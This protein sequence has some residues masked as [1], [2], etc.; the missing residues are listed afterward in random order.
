MKRTLPSLK[1][2]RLKSDAVCNTSADHSQLHLN[3]FYLLNR[4]NS[5]VGLRRSTLLD[6]YRLNLITW[7]QCEAALDA[8]ENERVA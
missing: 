6:A 7:G 1:S 4:D 8:L 3:L 2:E 5:L